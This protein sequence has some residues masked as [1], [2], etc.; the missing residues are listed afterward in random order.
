M[1]FSNLSVFAAS[2]DKFV[3][4]DMST[5][6]WKTFTT[7]WEK[8]KNDY[9]NLCLTQGEDESKINMNWNIKNSKTVKAEVKIQEATEVVD[10]KLTDSAK[11]YTGKTMDGYSG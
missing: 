10:G 8:I 11:C 2:N 3:E 4:A 7:E 6:E 1:S 9:S 5:E